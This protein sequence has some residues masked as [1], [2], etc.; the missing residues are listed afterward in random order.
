VQDPSPRQLAHWIL[1][2]KPNLGEYN[3]YFNLRDRLF[4]VVSKRMPSWS[5]EKVADHQEQN[6]VKIIEALQEMIT[7]QSEDGLVP[8]IELDEQQEFMKYSEDNLKAADYLS[9]LIRVDSTGKAFERFCTR[10][11]LNICERAEHCGGPND[12]GIDFFGMNLRPAMLVGISI[13]VKNVVY[14]QAKRYDLDTPVGEP[15]IRNLLGSAINKH[16]EFVRAGTLGIL[17]PIIMTFWTTSDFHQSAR[18]LCQTH[19]VWYV[20]GLSAARLGMALNIDLD[21]L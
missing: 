21:K 5:P 20:N 15:D 2:E 4:E 8:E 1:K 16:H 3:H 6:I 10:I 18:I 11:L 19:G 13:P 7:F 17:T 12:H 9:Q 14:G